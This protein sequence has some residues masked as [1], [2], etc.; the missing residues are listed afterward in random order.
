MPSNVD[1][2]KKFP[3]WKTVHEA[4]VEAETHVF[5]KPRTS[6][7]YSRVTLERAVRWLYQ[8]DEYLRYPKKEKPMLGDLIYE[9]TFQE[10]LSPG[11]FEPLKLIV[12]L[13]NLAVHDDRPMTSK[14][15]LLVFEH[16]FMF[17]NWLQR[18][19][20]EPPIKGLSFDAT[21]I[22]EPSTAP[23]P[24]SLAELAKLEQQ[25]AEK[26]AKLAAIAEE[27]ARLREQLAELQQEKPKR[28]PKPRITLPPENEARTRQLLIDV[29]LREAH[30]DPHGENV[31]EFSVKGMPTKSNWGFAD[32]VL[33]GDNGLPLAVIE[34]KSTVHDP[35]KGK[36]QAELYA[37]QLEQEYGQRP[38][39][40]YTNGY[41]TWFWDDTFYPPR[42][43]A[44][45]FRKDELEWMIQRR[46]LR[47][48]LR[49]QTPDTK[50]A[51]RVYQ[52]E[53]IRRVAEALENAHRHALLVMATGTGKTR[54][55]IALIDFLK[56]A[57]WIKNVLLLADRRELVK[58]AYGEFKKHLP[59]ESLCNLLEEKEDRSA[60]IYFST[61]QTMLGFVQPKPGNPFVFGVG[62]FDLIIIDEAHRSIYRKYG[63]I[64]QYFDTLLVGLTATPKAEVD[65]DTYRFFKLKRGIP[66]FAYEYETAVK[67]GYLVPVKPVEVKLKFLVN[68]IDRSELT[69]EEQE[70]YDEQVRPLTKSDKVEKG[71]LN[72]WLFNRDTVVKVLE[73]LMEKGIKVKG[74]D[75]LGKTIIFART[76]KHAE[77]IVQVFD[78]MY[79]N[80]KGKFA[81]AVHNKVDHVDK[82]I[83]DFKDPDKYPQIAV[84]VDMLD[85]GIDIPEV[86]NLVMFRPVFSHAKFWQMIGRG[87]RL[88][89]DLFGPGQNKTHA[90][91]F[92]FCGN[93]EFFGGF[94]FGKEK[95]T[96]SNTE[97]LM[98]RL[99]KERVRLIYELQEKPVAPEIREKLVAHVTDQLARMDEHHFAVRRHLPTLLKYRMPESWTPLSD[100]EKEEII[101]KLAL[102]V[103]DDEPEEKKR[104]DLLMLQLQRAKL[105]VGKVERIHFAANRLKTLA[106][107][108]YKKRRIKQIAE[109]VPILEKVVEK[110]FFAKGTL[111]ELEKIRLALRELLPLLDK[112]Q[113]ESIYTDFTDEILGT[114]QNAETELP[115]SSDMSAYKAHVSEYIKRHQDH[116]AIQKLRRNKPITVYDLQS[117][118]EMFFAEQG[119]TKEQFEALF[120][121][122]NESSFGLFVRSLLGLE[123]EAA[124]EAFADLLSKTSLNANQIHFIQLIIDYLT[125]NGTLDPGRLME[126]PFVTLHHEGVYGLFDEE[127]VDEIVR[128]VRFVQERAKVQIG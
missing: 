114:G 17:L 103:Y 33:W 89:S 77:F 106:T 61:Y 75:V 62:H 38:L 98:Q 111:S 115:Q 92:D 71:A 20:G 25:I 121:K 123:R 15:S 85:T 51:G 94:D 50:I 95:E 4:A 118:E 49:E 1:F 46:A 11:M 2:L 82:V 39:I 52:I 27:N 48:P 104:F 125:K 99:F 110:D 70:D 90:L 22:P 44:S 55:A 72:R 21:L 30:W 88:C 109:H 5:S 32:Y 83:S 59:N 79:P 124:H 18:Y 120:G 54:T 107:Q 97:S 119:G 6:L 105:G 36:K 67:D 7:F 31:R 116:I 43:V 65:R 76:Q 47:K 28:E 9:R 86:V 108:L 26:D 34:A 96:G 84:S 10:N 81:A 16:L 60:R 45:F 74:G 126:E 23:S 127:T 13:G 102:I 68:G 101:M 19:Y 91:L 58:Q 63:L 87:T 100:E 69:P 42:E 73:H 56:R 112:K 12:K 3:Q 41:E 117:F 113:R 14:E 40:F 78:E 64:F 128:V 24:E 53:A 8:H 57:G 35:E 66:T 80:Y 93:V 122:G 37:D 29:M